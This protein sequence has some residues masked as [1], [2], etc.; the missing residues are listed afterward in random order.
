M[1]PPSNLRPPSYRGTLKKYYSSGPLV[2]GEADEPLRIGGGVGVSSATGDL[3]FLTA[4]ARKR[5]A[6]LEGNDTLLTAKARLDLQPATGKV[7][8][9]AGVRV[10]RRL[11]NFTQRQDVEVAAGLDLDW[12]ARG[13]GIGGGGASAGRTT[14]DGKPTVAPYLSVRENNWGLHLRRGRWSLTYDL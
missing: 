12:P 7:S 4:S 11:L 13:R 9:R 6:L 2:K 3:P 5:V 1:H 10:S 14:G 8:R